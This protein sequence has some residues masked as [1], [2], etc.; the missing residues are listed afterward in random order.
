[1]SRYALDQP[2][3]LADIY[4]SGRT[5]VI[6]EWDGRFDREVWA[7]FDLGRFLHV[8]MPITLRDRTLGVI[9]V[10]YDG[11]TTTSV[12]EDETQMLAAFMDQAAV[13]LE[14]VRLFQQTRARARRERQTYDI[15]TKLRRSPDIATI[16]QTAVEEL[17]HALRADRAVVRLMTK[18]SAE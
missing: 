9:Q 4:R 10:V 12:T 3:I 1:M 2:G 16:L 8:Y 6:Q 11:R 14:N 17:G 7:A 5:E 13:A 18:P 15:T